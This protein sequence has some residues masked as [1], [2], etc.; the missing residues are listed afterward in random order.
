[1]IFKKVKEV[2]RPKSRDPLVWAPV[3]RGWKGTMARTPWRH[4]KAADRDPTDGVSLGGLLHQGAQGT[5]RTRETWIPGSKPHSVQD[6]KAP[7]QAA[8][9]QGPSS[10]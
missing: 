3:R 6:R 9:Q 5:L 8:G 7:G 10:P 2:W 1:M 4:R